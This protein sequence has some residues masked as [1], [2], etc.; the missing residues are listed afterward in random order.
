[1]S[2]PSFIYEHINNKRVADLSY[3]Q[4][5]SIVYIC[6]V[7][8]KPKFR[9]KGIAHK[10]LKQVVY[11]FP[12]IVIK[13]KILGGRDNLAAFKLFAGAGF[14]EAMVDDELVMTKSFTHNSKD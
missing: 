10:L 1:M 11:C 4:S 13:A 2:T 3:Y 8:V 6:T 5:D 7:N 12:N 9:G 14:A